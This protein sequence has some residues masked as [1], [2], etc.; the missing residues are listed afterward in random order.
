MAHNE[1]RHR[2]RIL[3]RLTRSAVN[4]ALDTTEQREKRPCCARVKYNWRGRVTSS[5]VWTTIAPRSDDSSRGP[6]ESLRSSQ[7]WNRREWE[8]EREWRENEEKEEEEEEWSG[9]VIVKRHGTFLL[10]R[11]FL[12]SISA[13][14]LRVYPRVYGVRLECSSRELV[15]CTVES[16]FIRSLISSTTRA[17]AVGAAQ[18]LI[19][20]T[21]DPRGTVV[22]NTRE[23]P[24]VLWS[25]LCTPHPINFSSLLLTMFFSLSCFSFLFFL[26]GEAS[27]RGWMIDWCQ[28][29]LFLRFRKLD[30]VLRR[31][32]NIFYNLLILVIYYIIY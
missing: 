6:R 18:P 32:H 21:V 19:A 2:E 8:R 9:K 26:E 1:N 25:G 13:Y 5:R 27:L 23:E 7:F 22:R 14:T 10:F 15:A 16:V 17:P 30:G 31:E 24:A 28:L 4:F 12:S 11:A 20:C 29:C 3:H